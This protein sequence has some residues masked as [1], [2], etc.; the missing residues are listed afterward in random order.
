MDQG[1]PAESFWKTEAKQIGDW[2]VKQAEEF[3]VKGPNGDGSVSIAGSLGK[4]IAQ[5]V[6]APDGKTGETYPITISSCTPIGGVVSI[7][8]SSASPVFTST[9]VTS[10][11]SSTSTPL[12]VKGSNADGSLTVAGSQN[13]A[14][15]QAIVD[16]ANV[17][18]YP[19]RVMSNT[20]AT[21]QTSVTNSVLTVK[22]QADNGA[23]TVKGQNTDESISVGGNQS[24]AFTQFPDTSDAKT[25][26][27]HSLSLQVC[28][29]G[30]DGSVD[31]GGSH[32]E[33]FSQGCSSSSVDG[34]HMLRVGCYA[35]GYGSSTSYVPNIA[36][37]S[38]SNMGR[39]YT[40]GTAGLDEKRDESPVLVPSPTDELTK[41]CQD[42]LQLQKTLDKL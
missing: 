27:P 20:G 34:A 5:F 33:A 29:A 14:L 28:G 6:L 35:N 18:S 38:G 8:S 23:V 19:M 10:I 40:Y 37:A 42:Y 21:W 41:K 9:A 36:P 17:A 3:I 32:L 24:K 7:S 15:E 22:G 31:V 16:P 13:K 30:T 26:D 39:L 25:V 12:Y 4:A 11:A 1:A 2:A